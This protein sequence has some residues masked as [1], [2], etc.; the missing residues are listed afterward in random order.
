MRTQVLIAGA[1]PTGL[2]AAIWLARQGVRLRIIDDSPGPGES[3]RAIAVQARILEF[4]RQ[5]GIADDVVAAGVRAKTLTMRR[6]GRR[7]ATAELSDMGRGRSAFPFVLAFAQDDHERLLEH[8]LARLGVTVERNTVLETI[9]QDDG[10]VRATLRTPAGT[11]VVEA[12]YLAGCDGARSRTRHELGIAFPGG[13]YSQ[14]FYVADAMAHG[15]AASGGVQICISAKDFC[16]VLPVRRT[17]SLRLIG[18]VPPEI[19]KKAQ[20]DFSDVTESIVR[21][22][23]LAL[24]AVHWFATY[25][26]H[27][28]IAESFRRGRV[29]LAGDAAHIHS[30]AGG[31]GMNTGIG[32]AVNLAWKL[33]AVVQGRAAPA[34]L[35]SYAPERMAFARTLVATTDRLFRFITDRSALGTLLRTAIMPRAFPLAMRLPAARRFL[36]SVVS[37]IRIQYRDSALSSG[38]AGRVHGGDRLP[39]LESAA[40]DNFAPLSSL[41]WQVHVYGTARSELRATLAQRDMPL[42]VF[43]WDERAAAAGLVRDATYLVRPDGHVAVAGDG[44][45]PA[46]LEQYLSALGIV[47]RRSAEQ[48]TIR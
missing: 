15:D 42:H 47:A 32:D 34:L 6:E 36:F 30:P 8:N 27:H 26:V 38:R 11:E 35:D 28:R 5:L 25:R 14:V 13:T 40:G 46:R 12:D 29:F 33:A 31:Q 48:D 20:I 9:T 16:L 10:S 23:G 18:I 7:V 22:T 19:E 21:N 44:Q 39:W 37:Q 41:D 17:G 3:S 1:G 4:Y 43:G 24:D 2:V 45:D